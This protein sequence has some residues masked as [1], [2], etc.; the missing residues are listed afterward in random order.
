[1]ATNTSRLNKNDFDILYT[2]TSAR[3]GILPTVDSPPFGESEKDYIEMIVSTTTG[4]IL[5]SFVIAKG[6]DV[7]QHFD[8]DGYFVKINPGIFMREKGY[9]SGEYNIEFNFL[10]E[11]AGSTNETILLTHNN[12]IWEGPTWTDD[13]G[14]I[15]QTIYD[16][17][18]GT[19]APA[20]LN[21]DNTNLL[22]EVSLKY[23]I[24]EISSDR[25]EVRLLPFS[26][27]DK[28]YREEFKSIGKD[29]VVITYDNK[30]NTDTK[31]KKFKVINY[32]NM[33]DKLKQ[34]F[35]G[36]ELVVSDAFE[37]LD[38]SSDGSDIN[39]DFLV[40]EMVD[41]KGGT[42]IVTWGENW[43]KSPFTPL[44]SNGVSGKS[45]NHI[46]HGGD[47]NYYVDVPSPTHR[48][49]KLQNGYIEDFV[50][51]ANKD[52]VDDTLFEMLGTGDN[53]SYNSGDATQD[54]ID[55]R[56]ALRPDFFLGG[57]AIIGYDTYDR[58]GF[59]LWIRAKGDIKKLVGAKLTID[60]DGE[61]IGGANGAFLTKFT[62]QKVT[63]FNGENTFVR[64]TTPMDTT[65]DG[66]DARAGVLVNLNVKFEHPLWTGNIQKNNVFGI[67]PDDDKDAAKNF[68]NA[69]FDGGRK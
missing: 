15:L 60:I 22:Q 1:M 63:T 5:E 65:D 30:L 59:P 27:D 9:F 21:P 46:I 8:E 52:D 58:Y 18:A 24:D 25:T 44:G 6:S 45:P 26:I 2:G 19:N 14:N 10:R 33:D 48:V 49:E 16:E 51:T 39:I 12:Q 23:Y 61:V 32:E 47:N 43:K 40:G 50:L 57:A 28:I 35:I 64:I 11:V 31:E 34:S 4:T 3:K 68:V 69:G 13:D 56:G 7:N 17:E 54:F 62:G 20:L 36:G 55:K 41:T 38:F 37:L 53:Q 42:R 29:K 67:M 66:D